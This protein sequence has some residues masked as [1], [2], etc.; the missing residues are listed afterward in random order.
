MRI[1][2]FSRLHKLPEAVHQIGGM[3]RTMGFF[4]N[5]FGGGK[6]KQ[7]KTSSD[8][9]AGAGADVIRISTVR[10]PPKQAAAA[11]AASSLPPAVP[12]PRVA[13]SQAG[14][15]GFGQVRLRMRLVAAQRTGDFKTAYEAARGLEAI[16]IKA[17]RRVGARIWREQAEQFEAGL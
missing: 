9:P 2:E 17:G 4:S 5:L 8:R 14:A 11:S 7:A 15:N 6:P 10:A 12:E 3:G 16:Q 13:L 1:G